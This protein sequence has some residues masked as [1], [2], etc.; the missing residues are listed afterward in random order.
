MI[1]IIHHDQLT[2]GQ[3][4]YAFEI[5]GKMILAIEKKLKL[6]RG[7]DILLVISAKT[8]GGNMDRLAQTIP[9]LEV[10]VVAKCD[11]VSL[12]S[13]PSPAMRLIAQCDYE[14]ASSKNLGSF[15]ITGPSSFKEGPAEEALKLILSDLKS[16]I[17]R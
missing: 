14:I 8:H 6:R 10:S 3:I 7:R 9:R 12:D 4:K 17:G 11:T 15:I 1:T 5:F 2:V 16:K 13:E